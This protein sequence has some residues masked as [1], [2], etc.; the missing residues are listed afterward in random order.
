MTTTEYETKGR[1]GKRQEDRSI[2]I[3]FLL[4]ASGSMD[5]IRAATIEGFNEFLADQQ[6]EGGDAAMT[7]TF[8]NTEFFTAAEAVP[9]REVMPLSRE[10]YVPDGCTALFDAIGHTMRITDDFVAANH[11]DQV[12]FVIMTD[13]EENSSREFSGDAVFKMISERQETAGYE[14]IYLGA[15]QDAIRASQELG[16]YDGRS[17]NFAGTPDASRAAMRDLSRNVRGY[18]RKG[19]RQLGASEWFTEE[20]TDLGRDSY[21]EHKGGAAQDDAGR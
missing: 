5:V 20:H 10:T 14:F 7:L 18:R 17:M 12:L 6:A 1:Q 4:D 13:G 9:V 21:D 2:L 3:N 15:N 8:F 16:M 19:E 11:P